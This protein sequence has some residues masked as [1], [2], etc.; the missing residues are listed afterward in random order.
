MRNAMQDGWA[1][2]EGTEKMSELSKIEV[3]RVGQNGGE[4]LGRSYPYVM[5]ESVDRW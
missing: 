3:I 2:I 1:E 4:N 5:Y